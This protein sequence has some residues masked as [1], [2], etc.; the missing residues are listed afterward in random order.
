M[1]GA[2]GTAR[3]KSLRGSTSGDA[4]SVRANS[5]WVIRFEELVR[6]PLL[7]CCAP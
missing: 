1:D 4:F 6:A 7:H 2:S 5:D 3:S